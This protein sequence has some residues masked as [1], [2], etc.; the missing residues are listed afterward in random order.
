MKKTCATYIGLIALSLFIQACGQESTFSGTSGEKT[1]KENTVQEN[2][3]L[4]S[5]APQQIYHGDCEAIDLHITDE[6]NQ[7]TKLAQDQQFDITVAQNAKVYTDM[8]CQQQVQSFNFPSGS[9][10]KT[11][12]VRSQTGTQAKVEINAQSN[13]VS[14][15]SIHIDLKNIASDIAILGPS[16]MAIDACTPIHVKGI[17]SKDNI[18]YFRTTKT[19][20][21]ITASGT[22]LTAYANSSCSQTTHQIQFEKDDIEHTF[23]LRGTLY[24]STFVKLTDQDVQFT[25]QTLQID[26]VEGPNHLKISGPTSISEDQC[27]PYIISTHNSTGTLVAVTATQTI[28]LFLARIYPG[29]GESAF[30]NVYSDNACNNSIAM[31][32][33]PANMNQTTVFVKATQPETVQLKG[34]TSGAVL[35]QDLHTIQIFPNTT[36]TLGIIGPDPAY[37]GTCVAYSIAPQFSA[38]QLPPVSVLSV[39]ATG[40]GIDNNVYSDNNCTNSITSLNIGG[41]TLPA[42]IYI[43]TTTVGGAS[44]DITDGNNIYAPQNKTVNV[45]DTPAPPNHLTIV[46]PSNVEGNLCTPMSVEI[47][48][49]SGNTVPLLQNEML[50]FSGD[51][52]ETTPAFAIYTNPGCT[53]NIAQN[54]YHLSLNAGQDGINLFIKGFS[55]SQKTIQLEGSTLGSA[56][57]NISIDIIDEITISNFAYPQLETTGLARLLRVPTEYEQVSLNQCQKMTIKAQRGGSITS[58]VNNTE[59]SFTPSTLNSIYI[60]TDNQ[61]NTLADTSTQRT[62]AAGQSSKDF[63]IQFKNTH[64]HVNLLVQTDHAEPFSD[65]KDIFIHHDSGI[66]GKYKNDTNIVSAEHVYGKPYA[67]GDKIFFV[68]KLDGVYSTIV[69]CRMVNTLLPCPNTDFEQFLGSIDTIEQDGSHLLIGGRFT[70]YAGLGYSHIVRISKEGVVDTTFPQM[71]LTGSTNSRI[72]KIKKIGSAFYVTG[73]FKAINGH[74]SRGLIKINPNFSINTNFTVG[75]SGINDGYNLGTFEYEEAPAYDMIDGSIGCMIVVGNFKK[76]KLLTVDSIVSVSTTTGARCTNFSP[77]AGAKMNDGSTGTIRNIIK[78]DGF[79]SYI[80]A[81]TF[82]SYGSPRKNITRIDDTGNNYLTSFATK[83]FGT[84]KQIKKYPGQDCIVAVG[85][86]TSAQTDG[87]TIGTNIEAV[88]FDSDGHWNT[89]CSANNGFQ[90]IDIETDTLS[91]IDFVNRPD[92]SGNNE[93]QVMLWGPEYQHTYATG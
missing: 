44:I 68:K 34:Q 32:D 65:Q 92:P 91:T 87:T 7:T 53:T 21:I 58:F 26:I 17:D 40:S 27:Q 24:G 18:A 43:Q 2:L 64:G 30:T 56:S 5:V 20:D 10:A 89:S 72:T 55:V 3:H 75:D 42:T 12:F 37:T 33:I 77:T 19:F 47:K 22:N 50:T 28:N 70:N 67:F 46:S 8:L 49:A 54:N 76:Y 81:G 86:F 35:I 23:Y 93:V 85:S 4:N 80:I 39:S 78:A 52:T 16:N 84:V 71:T 31:V 73:L 15:T 25:E 9:S 48:D 59:I 62:I 6:N 69:V 11:L 41:S 38:N 14:G 88:S 51:I 45:I 82:D 90:T 61:C 74:I 83:L 36:Y 66:Y 63:Y 60:Y 1:K 29:F 13:R 79:N 57:R